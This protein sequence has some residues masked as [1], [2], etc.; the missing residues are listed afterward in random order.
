MLLELVNISKSYGKSLVLNNINL[1]IENNSIV[2]LIGI[3]GSGKTTLMKSISDLIKHEGDII[4]N[5]SFEKKI[6]YIPD[7]PTFYPYMTGEEFLKFCIDS[8]S[9]ECEISEEILKKV[10]LSKIEGKKFISDY[11]RGMK[12]KIA[13]ASSLIIKSNLILFDEP[14]AA[15]DPIT[16]IEILK[17]IK[18][19]KSKCTVMVSS[20]DVESLLSIVDSIVLLHN[21]QI[22]YFDSIDNFIDRCEYGIQIDFIEQIDKNMLFKI[23]SECVDVEE[24]NFTNNH[25]AI[26][27]NL[28]KRDIIKMQK[29]L[30]SEKMYYDKFCK[31]ISMEKFLEKII[32]E[33]N[34][35]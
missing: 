28:Q 30:I 29:I 31:K 32:E 5:S 18:S 19:L 17:L 24:I 6:S 33:K 21:G 9:S 1:T 22:V 11:S 15:L 13:I 35:A 7:V 16:R 8:T 25:L 34:I 26:N 3:N 10:G 14:T 4:W 12:Q 20:H 23:I 2:G 27:K